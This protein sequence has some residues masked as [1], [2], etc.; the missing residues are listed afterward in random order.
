MQKLREPSFLLQRIRECCRNTG[1]MN[2]SCETM[3][4]VAERRRITPVDE[5][6]TKM[7]QNTLLILIKM[8]RDVILTTVPKW[9][10]EPENIGGF[11]MSEQVQKDFLRKRMLELREKN[12]KSQSDMAELLHC[13]KSTL[14]RVEKVGDSTSYKNVLSYAEMYCDSLGLTEEQKKLFLRGEKVVV[15]DTS[16]LLKNVQLIDELSKEY[17]RVVVPQIVIDELDNIKDRNTNN[18]AAK[19]WQILKSIG[20]NPNVITMDYEGEEDDGNNDS[21]IVAVARKAAEEFNCQV[22]VITNDAGFAAR[23]SGDETVRSLYLENYFV[24]KQ[25]LMDV[26]SLKKI[27]EYYADSYDDIEEKLGVSIPNRKDINAYLSNGY[28]LIISVV[29]SKHMPMNQR[30]EKIRWLIAH[31]ADVNR[32]DC[33]KYYFP[34]LSHSIQN[35]DFEMFQFLL[36]DCNANP[37]IGS[38]NPHDAG[39]IRQKNDGNMPLMIAAW[40]N[41]IQYVKELC[42]DERT[43]LNQQDGN[44]F[45][46]LIKA[47]YWGWLECRDIIIEAGADQKIVDRDGYTAEDRYHEFLETGR[48]KNANFKK[49][50]NWGGQQRRS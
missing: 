18:L 15:T 21:K 22:D 3:N 46:A 33:G 42:A 35:N 41:K 32:R 26:D 34:P 12:H 19:A 28:T 8:Q 39:K 47:C 48:R 24:T 30:K 16:A 17:S 27:N 7:L 29:R 14:S 23:L 5:I 25:D 45:T 2:G 13:N 43:S 38:R 4:A 40:D 1:K 10:L 9:V 31:G 11:I 44:G 37:N 36:H 49:K 50:P 6:E 20:D